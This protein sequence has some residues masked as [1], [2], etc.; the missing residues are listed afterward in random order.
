ML[1]AAAIP[2][3][4]ELIR[5]A[6]I[7]AA[8]GW[9][10]ATDGN[11]SARIN[12]ERVLLTTSGIEKRELDLASFVELEL[13]ATDSRQAST[14]WPMHRA[15]YRGRSEVNA[16][17]HVHSPYLTTFAASHRVPPVDLLAESSL[18]IGK[19]ALIPYRTPGT[20]DL[21]DALMIA[22]TDVSVYLLANHG[23]VATGKTVTQALHRLERAELLAQIAWQAAALGG[24]IPLNPEQIAR[25]HT[26]SNGDAAC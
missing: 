21:A 3:A 20:P 25:L 23:A 26:C 5:A 10:P 2:V 16:V 15:L 22:D 14:E 9:L 19:I 11:L 17:L 13:D 7:L 24:G 6:R 4:T 8:Y 1:S 18:T 12:S